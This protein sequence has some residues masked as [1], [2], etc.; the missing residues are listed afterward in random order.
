MADSP[1]STLFTDCTWLTLWHVCRL[2][3]K[4][5]PWFPPVLPKHE[6][7]HADAFMAAN[8]DKDTHQGMAM[9]NETDVRRTIRRLN[10]LSTVCRAWF[11]AIPWALLYRRVGAMCSVMRWT[12]RLR[13]FLP[14]EVIGH[15]SHAEYHAAL[16]SALA[17]PGQDREYWVTSDPKGG[18]LGIV[19]HCRTRPPA[20]KWE[21]KAL[22]AP[23]VYMEPNGPTLTSER[24]G[25]FINELPLLPDPSYTIEARSVIPEGRFAPMYLRRL[26]RIWDH[27]RRIWVPVYDGTKTKEVIHAF[28]RWKKSE[29][30]LQRVRAMIKRRRDRYRTSKPRRKK[31]Q[32]ISI[33]GN[34]S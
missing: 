14:H 29:R 15:L 27:R 13:K 24:F 18:I 25:Y 28:R 1:W 11:E 4:H 32:T 9:C 30:H 34:I 10:R 3:E 23:A 21:T 6:V 31:H 17:L 5:E 2:E 26:V 19:H 8:P 20:E 33:P 22:R 7:N 12:T 16:C